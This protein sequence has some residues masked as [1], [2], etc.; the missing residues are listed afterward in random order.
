MQAVVDPADSAPLKQDL[1]L[2]TPNTRAQR[3]LLPR[4]LCGI[5]MS[6]SISIYVHVSGVDHTIAIF[7]IRNQNLCSSWLVQ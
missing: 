4:S 1:H 7:G 3:K 5:S 6:I 2:D